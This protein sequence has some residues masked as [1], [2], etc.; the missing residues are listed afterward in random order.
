MVE[1][2]VW[3]AQVAGSNPASQIA[4]RGNV[5]ALWYLEGPPSVHIRLSPSSLGRG[6]DLPRQL[7]LGSPT[8]ATKG[9]IR[10][11]G[12]WFKWNKATSVVLFDVGSSPTVPITF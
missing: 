1:L 9:H 5:T 8:A 2:G 10:K 7:S 6:I 12:T 4:L 11:L 3:N